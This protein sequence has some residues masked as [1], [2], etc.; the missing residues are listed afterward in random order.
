M[1]VIFKLK[2]F[3]IRTW[4]KLF[5]NEVYYINGAETLPPPLDAEDALVLEKLLLAAE[6][7][8]IE[9]TFYE[10]GHAATVLE[11]GSLTVSTPLTAGR[12]VEPAFCIDLT[13]GETAMRYES[14]AYSEYA[15]EKGI[16]ASASTFS[17]LILGGHGPR[18]HTEIL[19][20]QS[21]ELREVWVSSDDVA[22]C[23]PSQTGLRYVLLP[24][25]RTLIF[26]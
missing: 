24:G 5:K 1:C 16:A 17:H 20:S 22:L 9:V 3:F 15:T 7:R 21:E 26:S 19:L 14:A 10:Y 11:K 12:S 23:C 18:P 8:E 25:A 6:Q 4:Q 13:F 2:C